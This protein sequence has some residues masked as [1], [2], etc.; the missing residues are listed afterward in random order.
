ME[1]GRPLGDP[2]DEPGDPGMRSERLDG[3]VPAR[4][5][6]LGQRGVDFVVTDLVEPDHRPAL[7]ALEPWHEVMEAGARPRRDRASA[8]RAVGALR[9]GFR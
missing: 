9:A 5:L 4:K 7:A 2:G 6:G 8:Q 3:R 1:F